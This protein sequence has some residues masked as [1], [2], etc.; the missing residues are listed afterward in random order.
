M[1]NAERVLREPVAQSR[2]MPTQTGVAIAIVSLALVACSPQPR[3]AGAQGSAAVRLKPLTTPLSEPTVTRTVYVP[4]YSSIY[5]G[6]DVRMKTV[7]LTATMSVRNVSPQYSLVL[8]FARYYDSAGKPIRDYLERPGELGPLA[9]VEFIVQRTDTSGGPG[10][11]FLVEWIG[12]AGIDEPLIEAVMVGQSGN[13]GI[14][15]ASPGRVL[16]NTAPR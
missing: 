8:N 1:P 4:I 5:L 12:P 13:A 9:T 15:F 14:S 3:D 7:E 6:L 16:T 10:A 2:P 11:N